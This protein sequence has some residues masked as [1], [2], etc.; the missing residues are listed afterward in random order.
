MEKVILEGVAQQPETVRT[1]LKNQWELSERLLRKLKLN[2]RILCNGKEIWVN[3]ILNPGDKVQ[4]DISFEETNDEILA[5]EQP[6]EILYEDACLLILNKPG[7]IVVHPT[8]LHPTGTLANGVKAYLEGKK[9]HILT[10]FVNRLDR[11][12]SGVI[13]FAKNEYTQ[14][15]LAKQMQKKVFEK[16]YIAVVNGVIS[17]D[18]GTIDFPIKRAP[19]SIM[20]RMTATDGEE[21]ITHFEVVQRFSKYTVLRL[22][23]ETGKTH[24]IRVHCKAIGHPIVGDGLYGEE[25]TELIGRQALHAEKI[26]FLHPITKEKLEITAKLPKDMEELIARLTFEEKMDS[27]NAVR[28]TT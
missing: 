10:R 23:L 18:S 24:Q 6:L 27:M 22:R 9:E 13:V 12:T 28:T 5:E 1:F 4:A 14:E 26:R 17:E 3:E 2:K 21:A 25:K 11:E 7:N 8:C 19:D 20:L 15:I 16:E